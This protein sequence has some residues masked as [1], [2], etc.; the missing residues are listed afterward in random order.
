MVVPC[1]E[2]AMS[3]AEKESEARCKEILNQ[4][5]SVVK[6]QTLEIEDLAGSMKELAVGL[7][8]VVQPQ[9]VPDHTL[10]P[11]V[12]AP[13]P[14]LVVAVDH[15]VAAAAP[16]SDAALV[17]ESPSRCTTSGLDP[18]AGYAKVRVVSLLSRGVTTAIRA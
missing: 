10:P 4:L 17:P 13:T 8:A 18:N 16:V 6:K 12:S 15:T 3:D 7:K 2:V 14:T 9:R 11:S 1:S 5:I